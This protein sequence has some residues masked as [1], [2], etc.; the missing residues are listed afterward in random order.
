MSDELARKRDEKT[1]YQAK[2]GA[3]IEDQRAMEERA[4]RQRHPSAY[5]PKHAK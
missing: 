1:M 5:K 3:G 4:A 2:H